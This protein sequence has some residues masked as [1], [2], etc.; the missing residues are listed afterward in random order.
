[1]AKRLRS[2]RAA[3]LCLP[4]FVVSLAAKP[5]DVS[6]PGTSVVGDAAGD[7]M[8]VNCNPAAVNRPCTLP[9]G[10][11][12]ALPGWQDIRTAKIHQIGKDRLDLSIALHEPLPSAPPA[13]FLAYFW[14]FQDGCVHPSPS[15]KDGI[16]VLWDG[17]MWFAHW[18]VVTGCNPRTVAQGNR[19]ERLDFTEDGLRVRVAL[20]E[21]LTQVGS[22]PLL[23]FAGVRR[24][25]F[26][27]PVFTATLALDVAPDVF[28]FNPAPPPP[29]V[30][31]EP[32]A[33]WER[34]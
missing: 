13:P 31:P 10:A 22:T 26:I 30:F 23:W 27:H 16:R 14:Q 32:S 34:R 28:A 29:L 24:L 7:L 6:V 17:N 12:H 21:L 9:P 5:Q 15:D 11:S 2:A 20:A 1:M 3:I 19:I 25:P 33:P 8:P 4:L 18:Y